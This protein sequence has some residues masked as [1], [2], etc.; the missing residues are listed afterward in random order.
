MTPWNKFFKE[1]LDELAMAKIVYDIGGG[2]GPQDKSKFKKY[3]LVDIDSQYK[4]DII[5]DIQNLPF[6]NNSIEAFYVYQFWNMLKI[7][8]K[9]LRSYTEF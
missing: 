5:A 3:I 4:P 2:A 6:Q 7:H 9:Q 1:K 8:L